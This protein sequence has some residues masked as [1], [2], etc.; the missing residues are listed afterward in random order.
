VAAT[1]RLGHAATLRSA[2]AAGAVPG[3]WASRQLRREVE[4]DRARSSRSL[5]RRRRCAPC[6]STS[7]CGTLIAERSFFS[8]V[9]VSYV[10]RPN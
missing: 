2:R 1:K 10:V 6:G 9:E 4:H 5:A 3:R 8:R 7:W